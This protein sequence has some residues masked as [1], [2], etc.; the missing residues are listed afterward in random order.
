MLTLIKQM[1]KQTEQ[2]SEVT[3][4]LIMQMKQYIIEDKVS[5]H[6]LRFLCNKQFGIVTCGTFKYCLNEAVKYYSRDYQI[7]N[8]KNNLYFKHKNIAIH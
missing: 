2:L 5:I 7:Q 4:L 6:T 1:Y 8:D 3:K